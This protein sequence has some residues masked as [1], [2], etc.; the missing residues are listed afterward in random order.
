MSGPITTVQSHQTGFSF[1]LFEKVEINLDGSFFRGQSTTE[2]RGSVSPSYLP[3][4]RET[5]VVVLLHEL[6]H[7]VKTPDRRWVLADDG[8]DP[9]LSLQNTE[10]II[11][12]CRPQ[13][14]SLARLTTQQE[15]EMTLAP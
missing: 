13:I 4:T 5:R 8:D 3:N 14:D 9:V 7:L 6:G 1:R 12:V 15:L 2:R 10:Q 11:S